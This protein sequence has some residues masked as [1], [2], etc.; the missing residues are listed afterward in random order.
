VKEGKQMKILKEGKCSTIVNFKC[1]NCDCEFQLDFMD[2]NDMEEYTVKDTYGNTRYLCPQ[3]Q[4]WCEENKNNKEGG[5]ME[6]FKRGDLIVCKKLYK[7]MDF[8]FNEPRVFSGYNI[9]GGL[10]VDDFYFFANPD[11]FELFDSVKE[12]KLAERK[13]VCLE[14]C[15]GITTAALKEGVVKFSIEDSLK[16]NNLLSTL[17]IKKEK[18]T[19]H[20]FKVWEQ[21]NGN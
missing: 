2:Q 3:C 8:Y 7:N 11:W 16:L 1:K 9:D 17:E 10:I 13:N 5:I 14:A 20:G 21:T 12:I 15:E 4:W 19:F 18:L 6:K